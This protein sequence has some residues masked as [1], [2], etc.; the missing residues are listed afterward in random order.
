MHFVVFVSGSTTS[1][2]SGSSAG[3]PVAAI[4]INNGLTAPDCP[5]PGWAPNGFA[6]IPTTAIDPPHR[7]ASPA[8]PALLGPGPHR[9]HPG[10]CSGCR[11]LRV[12]QLL[13]LDQD[14]GIMLGQEPDDLCVAEQLGHVAVDQHQIE[15]I[16]TSCRR[17]ASST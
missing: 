9:L 6:A 14:L 3:L 5:T 1:E 8:V 16:G 15:V 17:R 13:K 4:S 11:R 2:G 7:A 10:L 12:D